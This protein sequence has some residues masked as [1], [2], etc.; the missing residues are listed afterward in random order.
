[1]KSL[2]ILGLAWLLFGLAPY[3]FPAAKGATSDEGIRIEDA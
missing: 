3:G 1:M 2:Y